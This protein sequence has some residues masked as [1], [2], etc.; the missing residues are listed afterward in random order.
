MGRCLAF[1]LVFCGLFQGA[2]AAVITFSGAI[3]QSTADGT[4]PA[5]NNPSLNNITDGNSY[6]VTLNIPGTIGGPGTYHPISV[7]FSVPAASASENSFSTNTLVITANGAF[8]DFSLLACLTTGGGCF[9]GNQLDANFRIPAT[10]LT[11]SSVPAIGLDPPH[12]LDL[13]EDDGTTDI[14]GTITLYSCDGCAVTVTA[15][16]EPSSF[17]LL[18]CAAMLPFAW[19][20]AHIFLK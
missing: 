16:P 14:H 11:L 15:A 12:P 17:W 13:L 1:S 18:A 20:R 6:T 19:R 10:S 4:G 5:V 3:V 2:S 7:L 8:D 9:V